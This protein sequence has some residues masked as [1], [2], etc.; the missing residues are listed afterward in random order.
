[1]T[2]EELKQLKELGYGLED[3]IKINEVLT[4]KVVEQPKE[5]KEEPKVDY[6]AKYNEMVGKLDSVTK[7]LELAQAKNRNATYQEPK[8]LSLQ[9]ILKGIINR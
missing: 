9:D 6:E 8:E 2:T 7:A 1:M 3:I 5:V 4:P